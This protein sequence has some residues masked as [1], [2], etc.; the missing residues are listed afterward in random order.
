MQRRKVIQTLASV[1][2]LTG[3]TSFDTK[4]YKDQ[5]RANLKTSLNAYSFNK[6]LRSG[7]MTLDEMLEF[8]AE[9]GF[10]G[11]DLTG[12]Y[13]EGYP[14]VPSD[15]YIFSV[16]KKAHLLGLDISGTGVRND[17]TNADKDVRAQST[18]HVK[19][20]VDVA[21]KLGAPVLRVFAGRTETAGFSRSQ[22]LPWVI[23]GFH[24]CASYGASRGVVIAVQ[25]HNEF[26]KTTDQTIEIIEAVNSEWFGLVLD[27]GS[28]RQGDLYANIER[29][30][31]YAVNW[32]VKELVT[33]N[34]KEEDIDLKRLVKIIRSSNYK[35]YLPIET[36]GDDHFKERVTQFL[37]KLQEALK[38]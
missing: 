9:V 22:V 18:A 33:N 7:E 25:N 16:K 32:Q 30:I 17:F 19:Q 3:L 28:Y 23:E 10:D 4:D 15:D 36:F 24:E 1:P 5:K 2:L 11:I 27:T 20:W 6:S 12:Y 35:G 37:N 13:L 26:I 38:D 29:M 34:G 14:E 31:P 8:C 21:A